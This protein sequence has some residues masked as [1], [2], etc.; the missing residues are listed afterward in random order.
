MSEFAVL[1]AGSMNLVCM[2]INRISCPTTVL[3]L[4]VDGE[5]DT[6]PNMGTSSL[7]HF[8]DDVWKVLFSFQRGTKQ[9]LKYEKLSQFG[10][11]VHVQT[12][13]YGSIYELTI[14]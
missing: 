14:L 8:C 1:V 9:M 6:D 13:A 2:Y 4:L 3:S 5:A 7:F 12:I 10:K 11:V